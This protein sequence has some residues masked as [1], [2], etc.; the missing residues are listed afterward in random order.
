MACTASRTCVVSVDGF[1]LAACQDVHEARRLHAVR[2]VDDGIGLE[3]LRDC[4]AGSSG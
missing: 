2:H 1:G 3:R 4:P